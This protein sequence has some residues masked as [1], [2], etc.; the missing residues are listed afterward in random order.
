MS[1][2]VKTLYWDASCFIAVFNLQPTNKPEYLSALLT[3][4]E[5]MLDGRVHIITCT[6]FRAEVLPKPEHKQ[7]LMQCIGC[8][9]F[10][11]VEALSSVHELAG[12]LR[13]EC[14]AVKQSLHTPD[15]IHIAAG[16]LSGV[17]EIWTTDENLIRK[18]KAG[19]LTNTPICF[20][21]LDQLQ[22]YFDH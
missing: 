20:P 12:A 1:N 14:L 10:S 7:I 21:H 4:F 16:H 6:L 15:A 22:M 2:K 18:S 11:I 17:D 9:H 5:D 13:Q 19:Y 3:T 8:P